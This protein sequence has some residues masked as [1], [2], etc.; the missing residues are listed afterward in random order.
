MRSAFTVILVPCLAALA[1]LEIFGQSDVF[2]ARIRG[3]GVDPL[4]EILGTDAQMEFVKAYFLPTL[5]RS[6]G[7]RPP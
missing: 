3:Y 7:H 6:A 1:A 4:Q 5:T 2:A